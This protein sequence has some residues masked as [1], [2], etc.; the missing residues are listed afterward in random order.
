MR[1]CVKPRIKNYELINKEYYMKHLQLALII[2]LLTLF[3]SCSTFDSN[4]LKLTSHPEGTVERNSSLTFS[5]SRAMLPADSL[6][7]WTETPYV[8]FT[9]AISGKFIW[10]DS[11][12]LVFSPD[13]I[14]AGDT[15]YKAKLNE[16]LLVKL[17]GAK[18]YKGEGEFTFETESFRMKEAEFFYDKLSDKKSVGVKA[19]LEFTY[20]VNPEEVIQHIKIMIDGIEHKSAK[21]TTSQNSKTIP[22]EIGSVTQLEKEQ[23]ISIVFDGELISPETT[24][25]IKMEQPYTH[26]LSGIGIVEIHG[27][28]FG[29]DGKESWIKITT[30]Q[31]IDLREVKSFISIEPVRKFTVE[32]SEGR[33][34][35]LKGNF[36]I[37]T[38]FVVKIKQGLESVLGAKTKNEYVADILIGDME[39]SFRFS[40][41]KGSYMLLAG[42]KSLEIKTVNVSKL[43]V[44]TFQIFQNN[45]VFFLDYGRGYDYNYDYDEEGNYQGY[46]YKYRYSTDERFGR[47]L[48]KN[49]ISLPS[50]KNKEHTTLFDLKPYLNNG[51]KGF[52]VIQIADSAKQWN[53]TSKLV[54]L[55][56]IGLIVKKSDRDLMVFATSLETNKPMSGVS[57]NVISTNNQTLASQK[58]DGDGAVRFSNYEEFTK[59]FSI[60]LITAETDDDFNFI[61][62]QD[63]RVETSRFDVSGK[64]EDKNVY[65]AF[66]YGERNIYRPG[67]KIYVTGILRNLTEAIPANIPVR[68]KVINPRGTQVTEIQK[69]LNEAGSFETEYQTSATAPTGTYSFQ[70]YTGNNIYLSSYSVSVEDF[71]P[72][73]L[74]ISMESSK[75]EVNIG[76]TV[77][78]NF[79]A[80][81]FFG[82]PAA[83]RNWEFE[84]TL[85]HIPYYSKRFSDFRFSDDAARPSSLSPVLASGTTDDNGK[86][87]VEWKIPEDLISKGIME[88]QGRIAVFDES[89]R[90]VYQ[91]AETKIYPKQYF[92]GIKNPNSYYTSPNTQQK[93]QLVAVN[94]KDEVIK[95]FKAKVEIV[96][97]E[98]HS[99][100]RQNPSTNSLRYV[101]EKREVS[102]RS[103]KITIG[104]EPYTYTYSVP[105]SGEYNIKI[106][107]D[108]EE[109]Y[110]SFSFYAYDWGNT[111]ITSFKVDAEAKISMVFDKKVYAPGEKAKVLFQAPFDGTML[112]T[113]ERNKVFSYEYVEVKNK[114]ASIEIPVEENF[115][116]N[117]YVSAVLFRKIKE[118]NIP[119]LV[120]HG[121]EPLMVEKSSNKLNVTISA[122]EK[123]RPKTKQ[124]ISVNVGNEK[125][126]YLTI[127]AV[128]EGI[129]QVKN[130]QTPNPYGY[131]YA[132]KM[133]SM[134]TYDFFKDLIAEPE[135]KSSSGGG[136][137]GETEKRNNPL[138]VKRFNP[139]ALWSGIIKADNNG[140]AN[141]NFDI[142][143]FSG[144]LRL[145]AIAYKGD[146]FGSAEKGMKVADPIVITPALP[147]FISPEDEITMP[148]TAFNT[149]EKS[150]SLKFEIETSGGITAVSKTTIL[151][152]GPNQE[153]FVNVAL[154]ATKEIGKAVVKIKTSAFGEQLES[155]TEIP[156]RPN[157]PYTS[158]SITGFI[159]GGKNVSYNIDDKFL[160]F[161]RGAYITLSPY[162]VANFA[163]RLQYLVGYPHGCIEQTTSKA[164]PQIYLRDI[165][166][167]LDPSILSK[168]SPTYFVNEAITKINSMQR[169]DGN[170]SYWPSSYGYDS[171]VNEWGTVYA[172][173]FLVEAKKA[174]YAVSEETLQKALKALSIIARSKKTSDYYY[175]VTNQQ[176]KVKRIA[177]KSALYALYVLARAGSPEISIMNYYRA[178]KSLLTT[179]TK[180]LL[181]GA[182]AQSGERKTFLEL[183]PPQFTTEEAKRTSGDDFD[184]PIRA[185]ALV[186][187]ILLDSSPDDPN[188]PRYAEYLSKSY[189]ANSWYST[190]DDAF[191]LLA[192]G[193]MARMANAAKVKGVIKVG[194]QEYQYDGGNKKIEINP[195]GK[196]VTLSTQGEGRVYYSV[197]TQG[198]RND[199]KIKTEDKNLQIRRELLDR[200]GN[201]VNLSSIKQNDLIIV[202]LSLTSDVNKLEN[203]AITDLLPA[204][205]EIENPRLTQ[206]TQYNFLQ[207]VSTPEY[208]DIRDDRINIYTSLRGTTRQI[209]YY[210][211][212][213]VSQG[214]FNYTPVAAEAMYDGNYY[215][216]NGGGTKVKIGK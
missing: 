139:V 170:F 148:I 166:V 202:R 120:G 178:E 186:L 143:E 154:K 201:T 92:I 44:K 90:P 15:K 6:N 167:M 173:H 82:P 134:E 162:P 129:C 12:T 89:G 206:T 3:Y 115:V 113:V 60:K 103:D 198:I 140:N 1:L 51:Y 136:D 161:G 72:D 77:N 168:G 43:V 119:L 37:G 36:E 100:L 26:K 150:A 110:N 171:Y 176:V 188:I 158:E 68:L 215:S 133:L 104:N 124:K 31:E 106:S 81:N 21:V 122:P 19:N 125:D 132:K 144:E 80:L 210:M 183:L 29:F 213:A 45:L 109:G 107:K 216:A 70:L 25:K 149:T 39:P 130:Y 146:K 205:F 185:N 114:A 56:N 17:S 33:G 46:S 177:D 112:V 190:Q 69:T 85:Y 48:G 95:N 207:N 63:Y 35:T 58:T 23:N 79:E 127:A 66:L 193:K 87:T 137:D 49:F 40:S 147:R 47:E 165:A 156:V 38:P 182:F 141:V 65:D 8:E 126:V 91:I 189:Q 128:D 101:S 157:S 78:Y 192:F 199:G 179:D 24:T 118:M 86:G 175:Y 62:L 18:S 2:F 208:L 84:G 164:F 145:M 172:T 42:E 117:V 64:M 200:F 97:Y 13:E 53:S 211:V 11:S 209:F 54:S 75:E 214:E 174:G 151:E 163:K 30:S 197:V 20:A 57:I 16:E 121:F 204:G 22:I 59:K 93:I 116:P 196:T 191:T 153:R 50:Q 142:P 61:N 160:Q 28:D 94:T 169:W 9:P 4:T 71:I 83:G 108:G 138:G 194:N 73:R 203:I 102:V 152:V 159:D 96:R 76:E 155:V 195:F 7:K 67:E 187:N 180:F 123:I 88:A 41:E 27:H 5:F 131:F 99:V 52:Y 181:A 111:D 184:S 34:F 32:K 135:K 74:K 55:S 10:Q 105:I 212:R 98:W 14:L